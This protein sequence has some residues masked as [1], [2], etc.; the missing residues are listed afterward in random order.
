MNDAEV[1]LILVE[2][3]PSSIKAKTVA[4]D[5]HHTIIVLKRN[6]HHVQYV[7]SRKMSVEQGWQYTKDAIEFLKKKDEQ[8]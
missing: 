7:I 6:G 1:R 4:V 3:L 2:L 5:K 8:A